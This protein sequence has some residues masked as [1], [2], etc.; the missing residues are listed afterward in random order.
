MRVH[1]YEC[2]R[3]KHKFII[4]QPPEKYEKHRIVKCP[5]CSSAHVRLCFEPLE[6]GANSGN[7]PATEVKAAS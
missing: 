1:E 4:A 3:C 7:R 5:L 6:T 2:T